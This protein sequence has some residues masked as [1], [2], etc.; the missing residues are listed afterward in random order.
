MAKNI[1]GYQK[2]IRADSLRGGDVRRY[3]LD[4]D[5]VDLP[6]YKVKRISG[7]DAE[8]Q[9]FFVTIER[10]GRK[11]ITTEELIDDNSPCGMGPYFDN[12]KALK[13]DAE[14]RGLPIEFEGFC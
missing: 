4:K 10:V 1:S 11:K 14:K 6:Y 2:W 8:Y 3:V 9:V 12:E 13:A 5:R 7:I